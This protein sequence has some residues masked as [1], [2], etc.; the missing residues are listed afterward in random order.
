MLI[1]DAGINIAKFRSVRQ[2][3]RSAISTQ[4]ASFVEARCH[5]ND[6]CILTQSVEAGALAEPGQLANH[7][8]ASITALLS[9]DSN[10][11]A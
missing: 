4:Q 6:A 11:V 5:T 2:R 7:G 10:L 1:I 3:A 9:D 8:T